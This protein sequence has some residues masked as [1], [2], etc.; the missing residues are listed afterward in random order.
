MYSVLIRWIIWIIIS[1]KWLTC[2]KCDTICARGP[3]YCENLCSPFVQIHILNM[4]NHEKSKF[5]MAASYIKNHFIN[6][7]RGLNSTYKTLCVRVE[8][9]FIVTDIHGHEYQLMKN[10]GILF[11]SLCGCYAGFRS[12]SGLIHMS[13]KAMLSAHL[14]KKFALT[15]TLIYLGYIDLTL[16]KKCWC[17]FVVRSMICLAQV[18]YSTP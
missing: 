2:L 7:E 3:Y 14:K 1:H 12:Y 13:I 10:M 18:W 16:L 6:F 17:H 8:Y 15:L 5:Y 9:M 11:S 4:K